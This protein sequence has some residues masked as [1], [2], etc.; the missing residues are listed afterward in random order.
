MKRARSNQKACHWVCYD[1]DCA[2]CCGLAQKLE[3]W[4]GRYGYE[5][6]PLQDK[7]VGER[8]GL[9]HEA[10]YETLMMAMRLI[11]ESGQVFSGADAIWEILKSI[12]WC[13]PLAWLRF[14]P[15]VYQ[16]S[17]HVYNTIARQRH[18]HTGACLQPPSSGSEPPRL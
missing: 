13:Q 14:L 11:K 15:G 17:H 3:P 8:L 2:M 12:W 6:K 9:I 4:L 5:L 18:C 7:Q 1:A 16:W 10:D